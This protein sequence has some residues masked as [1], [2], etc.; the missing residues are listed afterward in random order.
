MKRRAM[1]TNSSSNNDQI[2][3]KTTRRR[4]TIAFQRR[5]N[6]AEIRT[7][8]MQIQSIQTQGRRRVRGGFHMKRLS[9]ET[10]E[11][12]R[13]RRRQTRIIEVADGG[14]GDRG[15]RREGERNR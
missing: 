7:L 8:R 3:V 4:S 13:P 6:F 14:S 10:A 9:S 15:R 11:A 2:I 12:E 1:T 5:K